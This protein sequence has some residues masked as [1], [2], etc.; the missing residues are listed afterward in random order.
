MRRSA[1]SLLVRQHHIYQKIIL[2]LPWARRPCTTHMRLI[3]EMTPIARHMCTG[4]G[5]LRGRRGRAFGG[6]RRQRLRLVSAAGSFVCERRWAAHYSSCTFI[7]R[8]SVVRAL[9]GPRRPA[10]EIRRRRRRRRR[11]PSKSRPPQPGARGLRRVQR[12]QRSG[13]PPPARR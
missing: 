7:F 5:A 11:T 10:A 4:G 6:R 1:L 3:Q 8:P 2:I 9:E 12:A 13:P